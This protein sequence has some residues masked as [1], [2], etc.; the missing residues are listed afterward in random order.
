MFSVQFCFLYKSEPSKALNETAWRGNTF[1]YTWQGWKRLIRNGDFETEGIM[2]NFTEMQALEFT[3]FIAFPDRQKNQHYIYGSG[4]CIIKS[5]NK[6]A[7]TTCQ[8]EN[9]TTKSREVHIHLTS[10]ID[11]YSQNVPYCRRISPGYTWT[12]FQG[13]YSI[14][15]Y[16]LKQKRLGG[17][18]ATQFFGN[19]AVLLLQSSMI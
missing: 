5:S 13:S 6:F 10:R 1:S 15:Q 8:K 17:G 7:F 14:F 12:I 19:S 18:R 4:V 16:M 2:K 9:Y 3:R 11:M